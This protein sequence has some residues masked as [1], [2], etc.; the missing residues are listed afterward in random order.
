MKM[1]AAQ[2]YAITHDRLVEKLC[3]S[4]LL[5]IDETSISVRGVNGYVWV[6]TSMEEVAYCFTPTREGNTIQELLR[7]GFWVLD[8]QRSRASVSKKNRTCR[9][10]P[11]AGS[12][13]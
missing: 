8:A 1:A 11:V 6:L 5:H 13:S 12:N 7:F 9:C 4:H 3:N 2:L 10:G